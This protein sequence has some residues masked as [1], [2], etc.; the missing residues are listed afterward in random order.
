MNTKVTFTL[1]ATANAALIKSG[2]DSEFYANFG[3]SG[4][5]LRLEQAVREAEAEAARAAAE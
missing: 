2:A 5:L 1:I 4:D 3:K